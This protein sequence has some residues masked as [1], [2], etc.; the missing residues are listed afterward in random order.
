MN[1]PLVTLEMMNLSLKKKHF[2]VWYGHAY[3]CFY[4]KEL[5]SVSF[6]NDCNMNTSFEDALCLIDSI[7]KKMCSDVPLKE[8]R[9][10]ID[11]LLALIRHVREWDE[12]KFKQLVSR[13]K[14]LFLSFVRQDGNFVC[15]KNNIQNRS[16][17]CACLRPGRKVV[18]RG[19]R[20]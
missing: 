5:I 6:Q 9:Q 19:Y 3:Y 7:S 15:Q 16:E 10:E 1:N 18:N 4:C 11:Y 13:A 20:L 12:E 2:P 14:G 8:I 17:S